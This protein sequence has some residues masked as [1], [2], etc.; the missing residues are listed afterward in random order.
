MGSPTARQYRFFK[1]LGDELVVLDDGKRVAHHLN[2]EAAMVWRLCDGRTDVVGITARSGLDPGR[3]AEVLA[4][5]GER[6]LLAD[7]TMPEGA[8]R[9]A[10]LRRAAVAGAVVA[11]VPAITSI[12]VPTAAE[13]FTSTPQTQGSSGSGKGS[14][15]APHAADSSTPPAGSVGGSSGGGRTGGERSGAAGPAGE[16][17]GDTAAPGAGVLG[18]AG[19]LGAGGGTVALPQG[20]LPFTGSNVARTAVAGGALVA[21]GAAGHVALRK[22]AEDASPGDAP[23]APA[24]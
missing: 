11:G 2:A 5:L 15:G 21:A 8:T 24:G 10:M 1:E 14:G 16:G 4:Q 7:A 17:A 13:A 22:R 18:D 3:T 6:G 20:T 12:L 19:A 23:A 9:R